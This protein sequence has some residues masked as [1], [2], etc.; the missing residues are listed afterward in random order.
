MM[1]LRER[2]MVETD[3]VRQA[4]TQQFVT[5]A[6]EVIKL[7]QVTEKATSGG[8][9]WGGKSQWGNRG[10]VTNFTRS[11]QPG[12]GVSKDNIKCFNCQ[13]YGHFAR[14]CPLPD[15]NRYLCS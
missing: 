12:G 2:M 5:A 8:Q 1:Q 4:M 10:S 7:R 13:A 14:E 6:K 3:E 15:R 11:A 9:S